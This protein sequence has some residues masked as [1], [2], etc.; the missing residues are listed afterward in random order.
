MARVLRL[1]ACALACCA[2]AAPAALADPPDVS[3]TLSGIV[4]RT[5]ADTS[6]GRAPITVLSTPAGPQR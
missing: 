1:C 6:G 2:I 4:E 5:H 3:V